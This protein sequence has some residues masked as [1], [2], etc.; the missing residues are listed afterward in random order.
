MIQCSPTTLH[1][2]MQALTVHD[3]AACKVCSPTTLHHT[4]QALTLHD[5]AACKVF[6]GQR[7]IFCY[8]TH[9]SILKM[10]CQIIIAVCVFYIHSYT[11]CMPWNIYLEM[12]TNLKH[13]QWCVAF[14]I[15]HVLRCFTV[16]SALIT[17][18]LMA[19]VQNS[20]NIRGY[21]AK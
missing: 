3:M 19:N 8:D 13:I 10:N 6:V 2:A 9:R 4:M 15:Y 5:M 20:R 21:T 11:D 16:L 18:T 7:L 14:V 12:D 17:A 1:H